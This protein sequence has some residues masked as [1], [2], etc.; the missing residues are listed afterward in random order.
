MSRPAVPLHAF[1][2]Y[3]IELEYMIVDSD[4][5]AVMPI[6]DALF[7]KAAG[8]CTNT[9]DAG[10]FSW[11]NEV[12]LHVVE[13]CNA[14]PEARLDGLA[15]GFQAEIARI[16]GLLD[17]FG[18]RLMPG[19]MHPWMDPVVETRLWPHQGDDIYHSFD[20]IFD[21]HSHGWANIQSMQLNLPFAGDAEFARLHAAVRLLL[22]ILPALAA[23]SPV[24]D[25]HV[26][27]ALDFR[28]AC[29]RFHPARVPSLIGRVIP[30]NAT[31]RAGYETE[32][33]APIYRDIAPLDPD[34][35]LRHEWLNARGAIPRFER[36]ALEIRVL[37]MQECPQADLAVAALTSAVA[38]ALFDGRWSAATAQRRIDT[39]ALAEILI[40]CTRDADCAVIDNA[41]YL[42]Q[43]GFP[44]ARCE[45]RELWHHLRA[46]CAADPLLAQVN[47][48]PLDAILSHGPL[49]RRILR[50]LG[51]GF[52][53]ERLQ[54]VY[55][56]LCDCLAEGRLFLGPQ[57]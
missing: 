25:G 36:D 14:L 9:V 27:A 8:S 11:S 26:R 3:G 30:D 35:V 41:D 22:P 51:S 23:S 47:P 2:G 34:G 37:D 12:V 15:A 5:L 49:A 32:V 44:Q 17:S 10:R 42:A 52:D 46:A 6:A 13:I 40:A 29:Y 18:A 7:R 53:H 33:L 1:S 21:C 48:A 45:A 54:A 38:R 20:R 28:M 56:E 24:A 55:R 57:A 50:A 39:A 19:A 16:E 43:L 31:S 4:S